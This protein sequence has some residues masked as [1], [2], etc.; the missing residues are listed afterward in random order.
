MI[1]RSTWPCSPTEDYLCAWLAAYGPATV[2]D[3]ADALESRQ[4]IVRANLLRMSQRTCRRVFAIHRRVRFSQVQVFWALSVHWSPIRYPRARMRMPPWCLACGR[5]R[6]G[7]KS[8]Y[9]ASCARCVL[10]EE[11]SRGN[12]FAELLIAEHEPPP[13]WAWGQTDGAR[14]VRPTWEADGPPLNSEED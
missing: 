8:G 14:W 3:I 6:P 4:T 12:A 5:E 13:S 10:H 2:R 7:A 1:A 9:C 11:A